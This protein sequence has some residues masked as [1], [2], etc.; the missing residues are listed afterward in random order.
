M[1]KNLT[2]AAKK[3][4][5]FCFLRLFFCKQ[6]S[7]EKVYRLWYNNLKHTAVERRYAPHSR[8]FIL[9]AG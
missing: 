5:L 9:A 2:A 8:L 3:L 7:L 4:R 6:L 1:C